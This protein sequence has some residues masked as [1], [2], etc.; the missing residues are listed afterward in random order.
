MHFPACRRRSHR[1]DGP[2][3]GAFLSL[4]AIRATLP[5]SARPGKALSSAVQVAAAGDGNQPGRPSP[6]IR[7]CLSILPIAGARMRRQ[8]AGITAS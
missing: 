6:A 2:R 5:E 1:P 3:C 7:S 8:S 4:D